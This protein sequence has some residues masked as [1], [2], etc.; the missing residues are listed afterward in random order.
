MAYRASYRSEEMG[1]DSINPRRHKP[2][3]QSI[4]S[5]IVM[6]NVCLITGSSTGLGRVLT[7]F[8]RFPSVSADRQFRP[9]IEACADW[10]LQRFKKS[11]LDEEKLPSGGSPVVLTRN[12]RKSGRKTVL[13]YGHYDVQPPDPL[14]LWQTPPFEPVIRDGRIFV[15]GASDNKGQLFAFLVGVID[16]VMKLLG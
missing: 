3:S 5:S 6:S 14:E 15:R 12:D 1:Q 10:L 2:P 16:A 4:D 9:H 11:G 7:E 8:L 13:I